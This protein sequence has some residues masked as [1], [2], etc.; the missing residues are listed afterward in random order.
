MVFGA[1]GSYQT[2]DGGSLINQVPA[3]N[4]N[5]NIEPF[6][7]YEFNLS[8]VKTDYNYNDI[9]FI[10]FQ[11]YP[12]PFNPKTIISWQLPE[13]GWQTLKIY[14]ALGNEIT[15]LVEGF[16]EAGR[17]YVEFDASKYNLSSGV[18]FYRLQA[19]NYSSI[20]KLVLMK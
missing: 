12:N 3:G 7:F 19:G 9:D 6:E 4:G 2:N 11:N 16:R 20:K 1:V 15:T 13:S 18:Y 17:H 8:S 10:L 5:G 14:D